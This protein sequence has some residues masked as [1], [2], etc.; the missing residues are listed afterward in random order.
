MTETKTS[1]YVFQM[2]QLADNEWGNELMGAVA[3]SAFVDNQEIADRLVVEVR[4]H[5]GWYLIYAVVGGRMRVV[6]T[7]NDAAR[8]DQDVREFWQQVRQA[9]AG[10]VSPVYLPSIRRGGNT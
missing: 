5:G 3:A 4:E 9:S 6:G 10:G 7:A 8:F 2:I 1:P